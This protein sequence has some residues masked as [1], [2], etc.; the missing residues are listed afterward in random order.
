MEK[1]DFSNLSPDQFS[2]CSPAF[3]EWVGELVV[4]HQ[5][6]FLSNL[7]TLLIDKK[8]LSDNEVLL[9]MKGMFQLNLESLGTRTVVSSDFS[10]E[11]PTRKL[12]RKIRKELGEQPLSLGDPPIWN[13]GVLS[14]GAVESFLAKD[15]PDSHELLHSYG[16]QPRQLEI[17]SSK[18]MRISKELAPLQKLG[19]II[20]RINILRGQI[21]STLLNEIKLSWSTLVE[22]KSRVSGG[23][24]EP[25]TRF[26][27]AKK[28]KEELN[29]LARLLL[30]V[31]GSRISNLKRKSEEYYESNFLFLATLMTWATAVIYGCE[32]GN[33]GAVFSEIPILVKSE[34]GDFAGRLDSAEIISIKDR[35]LTEGQKRVSAEISKHW[36]NLPG[37]STRM[38]VELITKHFGR[39][40]FKVLEFKFAYGDGFR[41]DINSYINPLQVAKGPFRAHRN[42]ATKYLAA[43]SWGVNP[44]NWKE[45]VEKG[46]FSTAKI[47]YFSPWTF[48]MTHDISLDER[49][50]SEEFFRQVTARWVSQAAE[51]K[52][53]QRRLNEQMTRSVINFVN[54]K[55]DF[56]PEPKSAVESPRQ[57]RLFQSQAKPASGM[58]LLRRSIR[59]TR[60]PFS[61]SEFIE[62]TGM[63]KHN[64][65]RWSLHYNKLLKA[66]QD[67]QISAN[68]NFNPRTGGSIRCP[69]C[70]QTESWIIVNPIKGT[71]RCVRFGCEM[72]GKILPHSIPLEIRQYLHFSPDDAR[73]KAR[74]ERTF[75]V[76]TRLAQIMEI[77]QQHLT[78]ELN[79]EHC[80]SYLKI[81]GVENLELVRKI[82]LGYCP[83]EV[84]LVK[85]LLG[86]NVTFEEMVF[87]GLI[88][89]RKG[90]KLQSDLCQFLLIWGLEK[91]DLE[92]D[93]G[94]K[95]CKGHPYVVLRNQITA[96]LTLPD[97]RIT[98]FY[99]RAMVDNSQTRV[100]TSPLIIGFKHGAINLKATG[101][102]KPI[103][104][105]DKLFDILALQ[106]MGATNVISVPGGSINDSLLAYMARQPKDYHFAFAG[107]LGKNGNSVAE[108]F[109]EKLKELGH[110]GRNRN[111][112]SELLK[113]LP[114]CGSQQSFTEI[115]NNCGISLAS[116]EL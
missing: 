101:A 77:V 103:V 98:G 4:N 100:I 116:L 64:Q 10:E 27:I 54:N 20:P 12:N 59:E 63:T 2:S 96:P 45:G 32:N 81:R 6:D 80:Q 53:L 50:L 105:T 82:G 93:I 60:R 78:L 16:C 7:A 79:H 52:A 68:G 83:N 19:F 71:F 72:K 23:L 85:K 15:F 8:G 61:S 91:D 5:A 112:V 88:K 70:R 90:V 114:Q 35:P 76:P 111:L 107:D 56:V 44:Q 30:P 104:I 39:P 28:S 66:I 86:S 69:S 47:I 1:L 33:L 11:D 34:F 106:K 99:G 21:S 75:L 22:I 57:L 25:E 38:L 110:K 55:E 97:G 74:Q 49:G 42:Q 36:K 113:T 41:S 73:R 89:F 17:S 92:R 43:A 115:L 13:L 3:Q 31:F 18:D 37:K 26:E 48:P 108:R 14:H 9:V 95:G 109:L 67:K 58:D 62:Q 65:P 51:K 87:Y 94:S 102:G 24:D 29:S 84:S 40:K 46:Y